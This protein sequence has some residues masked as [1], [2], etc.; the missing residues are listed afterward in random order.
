MADAH[1]ATRQRMQQEPTQEFVGRDRHCALFVAVGVI[2]PSE[3]D[4]AVGHGYETM[5]GNG[6]AVRVPGQIR[7]RP[8]ALGGLQWVHKPSTIGVEDTSSATP[9]RCRY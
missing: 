3:C 6:H 8:A 5:V 7:L 4:V 2:L 1:K 9:V